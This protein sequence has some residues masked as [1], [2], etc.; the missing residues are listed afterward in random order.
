[1]FEISACWR[2]KLPEY[3]YIQ[4]V[5]LILS[6]PVS[7]TLLFGTL[8]YLGLGIQDFL[9]FK[10]SRYCEGSETSNTPETVAFAIP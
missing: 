2:E 1:M 3:T 6:R 7:V 10:V 4:G 5:P 9:D 8:E